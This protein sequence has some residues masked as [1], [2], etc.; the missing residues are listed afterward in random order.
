MA[1]SVTVQCILVITF[2]LIEA[3]RISIRENMHNQLSSGKTNKK[4]STNNVSLLSPILTYNIV[5][6]IGNGSSSEFSCVQYMF[7][8]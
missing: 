3:K 2:K 1:I 8:E 7:D 5:F 6:F 4:I